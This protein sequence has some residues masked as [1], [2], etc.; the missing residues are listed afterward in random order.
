MGTRSLL[1]A[2]QLADSTGGKAYLG[3]NDL[4]NMLAEA[5][6]EPRITYT[7]GFYLPDDERDDK[8]HALAVHV[9]RPK[10]T[11]GYRKGYYAGVPPLPN[12]PKKLEPLENAL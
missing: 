1:D 8:F 2:P 11:L 10:L 12:A 7:L 5:I 4:E 3:R 9:N 6:E